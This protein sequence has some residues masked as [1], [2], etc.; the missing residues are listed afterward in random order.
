MPLDVDS[1]DEVDVLPVAD[2]ELVDMPLLE[3]LVPVEVV[4]LVL[5]VDVLLD[6][7]FFSPATSALRFSLRTRRSIQ[8]GASCHSGRFHWE[9]S[10]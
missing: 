6:C 9:Q 2:P 10:S 3:E 4:P 1:E 5:V 7:C 8:S